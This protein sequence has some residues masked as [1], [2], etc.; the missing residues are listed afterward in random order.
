MLLRKQK[1][2]VQTGV[3]FQVALTDLILKYFFWLMHLFQG[4]WDHKNKNK[5][6]TVFKQ[7]SILNTYY[8]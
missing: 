2:Y 1:K 5:I 6:L 8:H 7:I 3:L 4:N